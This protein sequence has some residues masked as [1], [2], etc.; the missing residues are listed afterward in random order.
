M[1]SLFCSLLIKSSIVIIGNK[2]CC[3]HI[4]I[5]LHVCDFRLRPWNRWELHSSG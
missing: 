5:I 1:E 3:V 4:V 2:V